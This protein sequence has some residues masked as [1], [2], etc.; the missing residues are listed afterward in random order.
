MTGN[1]NRNVWKMFRIDGIG[2]VANVNELDAAKFSQSP[3]KNKK[4]VD[5]ACPFPDEAEWCRDNADEMRFG[6]DQFC[7]NSKRAQV[8]QH[9]FAEVLHALLLIRRKITDQ[10]NHCGERHQ[11]REDGLRKPIGRESIV[12]AAAWPELAQ[13]CQA[14][15]MRDKGR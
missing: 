14:G 9:H 4:L 3:R 8:A 13:F 11:R 10:Q 7:R 15:W 12:V 1:D 2:M 6:T 5:V